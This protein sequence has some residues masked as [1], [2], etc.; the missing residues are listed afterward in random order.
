MSWS[1]LLRS[2]KKGVTWLVLGTCI[3][4][5]RDFPAEALE[6]VK[7]KQLVLVLV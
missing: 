4:H 7:S 3:S 5:G 1:Q 2:C 6:L